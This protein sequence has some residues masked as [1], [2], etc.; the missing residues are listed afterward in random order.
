M[1]LRVRLSCLEDFIGL[2]LLA[3]RTLRAAFFFLLPPPNCFLRV[4]LPTLFAAVLKFFLPL[5]TSAISGRAN[6]N[7]SAPR[8]SAGGTKFLRKIGNAVLP[9]ICAS[10]PN[11]RP[12][13]TNTSIEWN[14][15]L[16]WSNH[17][18]ASFRLEMK[19]G[20]FSEHQNQTSET[21]RYKWYFF[22]ARVSQVNVNTMKK[23]SEQRSELQVAWMSDSSCTVQ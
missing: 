21:N 14:L 2:T 13:S 8:R 16:S 17:L 9:I 12:Q 5:T 10:A 3:C 18:V 22:T 15:Y 7:K 11:P 23:I 20:S 6:S 19:V 1:S 4:C